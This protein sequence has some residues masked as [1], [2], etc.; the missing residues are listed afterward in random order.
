M[1]LVLALADGRT[2]HSVMTVVDGEAVPVYVI[3]DRAGSVLGRLSRIP[4]VYRWLEANPLPVPI[5]GSQGG[6]GIPVQ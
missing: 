3:V 2:V 6:R 5:A 1:G 4:E